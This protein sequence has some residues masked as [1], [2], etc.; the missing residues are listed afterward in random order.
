MHAGLLIL[1]LSASSVTPP[2]RPTASSVTPS[3]TARSSPATPREELALAEKAFRDGL[4]E[5]VALRMKKLIGSQEKPFP[6]KPR[7]QLLLAESWY[8]I[9]QRTGDRKRLGA[10]ER[11]LAA[12]LRDFPQSPYLDECRIWTGRLETEFRGQHSAA[13]RRLRELY[14]RLRGARG[15]D[16]ELLG[17]CRYYLAM[18]LVEQ[19]GILKL[20]GYNEPIPDTDKKKRVHGAIELLDSY[21]R[22]GAKNLQAEAHVLRGRALYA[23]GRPKECC[24]KLLDEFLKSSRFK[25]SP[26]RGEAYFWQAEA[27]Y[28]QGRWMQ[29]ARLFAESARAAKQFG[30]RQPQARARRAM[31]G[32]GWA[33]L[34]RA[35]DLRRAG[36]AGEVKMLKL[37]LKSFRQVMKSAN[38]NLAKASRLRCGEV[39]YLLTEYT[40]AIDELDDL[41]DEEFRG[42]EAMYFS[43]LAETGRNRHSAAGKLLARAATKL[44]SKGILYARVEFARGENFYRLTE[45][46]D[47]R[48]AKRKTE[49]LAEAAGAFRRVRKSGAR[50]TERYEARLW[51]ARVMAEQ[52]KLAEAVTQVA[53]LEQELP[54]REAL[55]QDQLAYYRGVFLLKLARKSGDNTLRQAYA[56]KAIKAFSEARWAGPRGEFAVPSM[57]GAAEANVMSNNQPEANRLYQKLRVHPRARAEEIHQ[58]HFGRARALAAGK[59][60]KKAAQYLKEK[61]LEVKPA[62]Q[63]RLFRQALK[64][65][66]D[67]LAA[68]DFSDEASKVYAQLASASGSQENK[69]RAGINHAL[70]LRK[71]GNPTEA[72]AELDALAETCPRKMRA[73]VLLRAGEAYLDAGKKTEALGRF[74]G[75][76]RI[77]GKFRV[78]ALVC[79]AE[80]TLKSGKFAAARTRAQ[81]AMDAAPAG[82]L[83]SARAALVSAHAL[84]AIGNADNAGNAARHYSQAAEAARAQSSAAAVRR[85]ELETLGRTAEAARAQDAFEA[86]RKKELEARKGLGQ[87]LAYLKRYQDAAASYLRAA[88]LLDPRKPDVKMLELAAKALELGGKP[89]A[90]AEISALARRQ[91]Q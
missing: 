23:R 32:R 27:R 66:A 11:L 63:A 36:L 58:A 86:G 80:L 48:A 31:Y 40:T 10:A 54:A 6:G 77:A 3:A 5:I 61:L 90:A 68:S 43:A 51:L 81:T 59:R 9:G 4:Y 38:D 35:G 37:A 49:L 22:S 14:A 71:A 78:R 26:L 65:R 13:E 28:G 20:D 15:V 64:L 1:I 67:C 12:F 55:R 83:S 30:R 91:K 76:G 57:L 24:E 29:A 60:Y 69:A 50:L 62:P 72:A 19:G 45:Q 21:V 44:K 7:A 2:V 87:A 85:K 42:I 8:L 74:M 82:S 34:K 41:Y 46:L 47:A 18:A 70:Q 17:A 56:G 89:A 73:E 16:Q 52:G 33:L 53:K 25:K 39:L 79:T 75:S 88:Y 84:L